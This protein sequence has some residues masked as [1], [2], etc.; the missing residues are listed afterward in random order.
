MKRKRIRLD[1]AQYRTPGTVWHITLCTHSRRPV[2]A[3]PVFAE[4]LS[5]TALERARMMS[6]RLLAYCVMPD[7]A[8]FIVAVDS[9]DVSRFVGAVKSI[10]AVNYL[11]AGNAERLWQRS[12]H[13]NGVRKTEKID[14]LV[15][16]VLNDPVRAGLADDW[17][18][19]PWVGGELVD[20]A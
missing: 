5:I 14:E 13:D 20:G 2:F 3:D 11:K 8:H 9:G 17:S 16:Y 18:E 12:F 6:I 7:H 15:G 1:V 4:L 10:V 19:Y